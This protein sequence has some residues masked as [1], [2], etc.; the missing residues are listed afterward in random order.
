MAIT[1]PS[2]YIPTTN[3]FIAHW[4]SVNADLGVGNEVTVANG[5]GLVDLSALRDSLQSQRDAVEAALNGQEIASATIKQQKQN[6]LERFGQFAANVR[7]LFGG[8]PFEAALPDAPSSGEAESKFITPLVDALNLWQRI[9]LYGT[10]IILPGSY[11][12]AEFM[13]DIDAL[14]AEYVTWTKAGSDVKIARAQRNKL[15]D[16][17]YPILKQYRQIIPGKFAAGSVFIETLPRLTPL[18]GAT[19]DAVNASAVWDAGEQ[20]A[21]ITWDESDNVNLKEYEV[22][23]TPG[24]DYDPDDENVVATI[25]PGAPRE[26]LTD[27]GLTQPGANSSFKVYV[28]LTTGNEKGSTTMVV[29]RPLAE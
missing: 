14:R 24:D 10:T 1:G 22:R 5:V 2:S 18:P 29:T 9:E 17:I 13:D 28:M 12:G 6:L 3:E 7:A 16:D 26:I 4:E 15:Q 8:G 23:Y 27:A 11:T 20:K 19:P 21:R 25:L